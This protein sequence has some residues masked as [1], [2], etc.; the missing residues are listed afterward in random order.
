MTRGL[1]LIILQKNATSFFPEV[2]EIIDA[3]PRVRTRGGQG[4]GT[5]GGTV[6]AGAGRSDIPD[7]GLAFED[8]YGGIEGFGGAME[9]GRWCYL[10]VSGRAGLGPVGG[11]GRC[12]GCLC[13]EEWRC[14]ESG[15]DH[16][17]NCDR[18]P[19]YQDDSHDG[20]ILRDR[21]SVV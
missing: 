15:E 18:L 8:A 2:V 1:W 6:A 20:G 13:D 4:V 5:R 19:T 14:E 21:K 9:V 7:V 17:E 10:S 11:S 16:E 3:I 12:S